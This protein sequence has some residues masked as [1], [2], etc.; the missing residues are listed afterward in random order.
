VIRKVVDDGQRTPAVGLAVSRVPT[1]HSAS[2]R[3]LLE[4][5]VNAATTAMRA[6]R[7][8]GDTGASSEPA[9]AS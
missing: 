9:P 7:R 8:V 1:G 6:K 5:A 2:G 3:N 4:Y